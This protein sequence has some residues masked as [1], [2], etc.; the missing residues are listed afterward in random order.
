M[1]AILVGTN[2]SAAVSFPKG[3]DTHWITE[4]LNCIFCVF[5]TSKDGIGHCYELLA[6]RHKHLLEDFCSRNLRPS[7]DDGVGLAAS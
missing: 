3:A 1:S 5:C 2:N 4:N 6:G 7:F